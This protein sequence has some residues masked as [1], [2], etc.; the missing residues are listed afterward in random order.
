MATIQITGRDGQITAQNKT[1]ARDKITK[2]EKY[3]DGTE[4]IE[5][6]LTR[7]GGSASVELVM[8][9]RKGKPL[10]CQCEDKDLYAAIDKVLDKAEALL[11]KRKERLK[12]HKGGK[13]AV[14][15][16]VSSKK[17][18]SKSG[19]AS[20]SDDEGLESYDEVIEKRNFG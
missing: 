13:P 8:S 12:D 2:L 15:S 20:S 7:S 6:I 19:A 14:R 18:A 17:G 9:V 10:V 3:F 1:H 4:K 11:T 16:R 5:A